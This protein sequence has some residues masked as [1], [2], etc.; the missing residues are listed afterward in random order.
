MRRALA[1]I[2]EAYKRDYRARV[3]AER[4]SFARESNLA[5]AI[6]RAA[7]CLTP[8][9]KRHSH[10]RRIPAASLVEA[11]R[12]LLANRRGIGKIGKTNPS[13][14]FFISSDSQKKSEVDVQCQTK[15]H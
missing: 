3:H 13:P 4:M 10:Q 2:V 5:R 11:C 1:G 14:L 7:L 9:G 12:R 6:E 8:D 15:T